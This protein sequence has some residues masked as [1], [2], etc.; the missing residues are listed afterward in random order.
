MTGVNYKF[1]CELFN[2]SYKGKHKKHVAD[3][4]S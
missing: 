1:K 3:R 2:Q 4:S